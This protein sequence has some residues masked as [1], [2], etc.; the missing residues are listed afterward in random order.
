ML[1]VMATNTE[2]VIAFVGPLGVSDRRFHA[3]AEERLRAYGYEPTLIKLSECLDELKEEG[4]IQTDL[5]EKPE[6][7]RIRSH[8]DAGDELRSK[9]FVGADGLLARAAIARLASMRDRREGHSMPKPGQAWLISSLK[10]PA[11][12][13]VFRGVYGPGFFLIGLFATEAKR[14][15]SLMRRG[16]SASEAEQLIRR[17]EGSQQKHGQQT[18]RTFEHADAWV[19]NEEELCRVLDLI[20]G[21]AFKTP[22]DDEDGMALAY[23]AALRSADLSRQVGAA[24]VSADGD[25]LAI[26]RNEVPA[27]GGG[28]YSPPVSGRP[29]ARDCDAGEDYNARERRAIESEIS[30]RIASKLA[31]SGIGESE[32]RVSELVNEA[33]AESRLRDITEYGRAVHA[34]MSALMSA[35]RTGTS[36]RHGTLY[37]TTF[38][39]HNCA[40]HLVAAGIARVVYVE[41]YPKSKAVLLH[42]DSITVVGEDEE[43][44]DAALASLTSEIEFMRLKFE[45][46]L[47]IGARRYF[48]LFSMR[49]G[50]GRE[51][52]RKDS[53]GKARVFDPAHAVPRVPLM[54]ATYLEME[55]I[56]AAQIEDLKQQL[57]PTRT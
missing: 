52:E 20:F 14:K 3:C 45:P 38:P 27:P 18:R 53:S 2:V 28:Q 57:R 40:K 36:V 55:A 22:T 37:C 46:F 54:T 25:V 12:V 31:A 9:S 43:E 34:E 47:G 19:S 48:D 44:D 26:G 24:I 13:Q 41:P 17:D 4:L 8:M 10:N 15:Q 23:V 16:M 39:C 11:E 42:A 6:F 7:A 35:A 50:I 29:S 32:R 21:D 49:L 30:E 51:L 5:K 33:L 1:V 56:E